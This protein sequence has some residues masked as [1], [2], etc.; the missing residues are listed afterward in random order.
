MTEEGRARLKEGGMEG[1]YLGRDGEVHIP[2]KKVTLYSQPSPPQPDADKQVRVV[3]LGLTYNHM[4]C[5]ETTV[6]FCG[7]HPF[8]LGL[9]D[10]APS[11]YYTCI[12]V[13]SFLYAW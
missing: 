1:A 5:Y 8:V 4:G 11:L 9:T 10:S 7:S 2:G 3:T 12:V 6:V 13:N